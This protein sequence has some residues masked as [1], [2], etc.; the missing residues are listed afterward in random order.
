MFV[1]ND[2]CVKEMYSNLNIDILE[3]PNLNY[4]DYKL[5]ITGSIGCGKSTICE[6]LK[7]VLEKISNYNIICYPEYINVDNGNALEMLKNRINNKITPFDFQNYILNVWEK[8]FKLNK[9]KKN[10]KSISIFERTPQD[11]VDCFGYIDR[12]ENKIT[13]QEFDFLTKK[14]DYLYTKYSFPLISSPIIKKLMII[15]SYATPI[16]DIIN[17]LLF[18]IS[19]DIKRGIRNRI[20]YIYS[21]VFTS[22]NRIRY[23]SRRGEE[24]YSYQTLM[25]CHERYI[26]LFDQNK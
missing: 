18:V 13:Q 23:R 12:C 8:T 6:L 3:L 21:D 9:S 11:S 19:R 17:K 1:E 25:K 26:E 22:Y 5:V 20:I 16:N 14:C 10:N 4:L 15:N 24:K 7:I 2:Y